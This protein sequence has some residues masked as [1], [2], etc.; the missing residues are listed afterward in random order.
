[1]PKPLRLYAFEA[2]LNVGNL[3]ALILTLTLT[4]I[5]WLISPNTFLPFWAFL[6]VLL[7]LL[8][9]IF[10]G[11]A[12]CYAVYKDRSTRLPRVLKGRPAESFYNDAIACIILEPSNLFS[13]GGAVS[14]YF[15][16]DDKDEVLVGWGFVAIINQSGALQVILTGVIEGWQELVDQVLHNDQNALDKLLVKP[17]LPARLLRN[18][19]GFQDV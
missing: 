5:V 4:I 8:L 2:A 1:M 9:F 15:L 3:V 7:I 14:V 12:T 19:G 6:L 18:G 11:W 10:W 16:T 17:T 13:H